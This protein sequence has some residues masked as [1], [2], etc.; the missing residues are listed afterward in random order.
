MSGIKDNSEHLEIDWYRVPIDKE[1]LKELNR[2]SDFKASLQ[3]LGHL[4]LLTL[5]GGT[6]IYGVGRWPWPL[7]VVLVFAHATFFHFLLNGFHELCHS[8]A[9]RTKWLGEAVLGLFSL[10][11]LNHHVAFRESHRRHHRYTLHAPYDSEVILPIRHALGP[12]LKSIFVNWRAYWIFRFNWR[13]AT[14]NIVHPWTRQLFP[15]S[16]PALRR[17]LFNWSRI[18]IAFHAAIIV[19]SMALA[20]GGHPR[21]LLLPLLTTF[22][23]FYGRWLNFLLND[24]QHVGLSDNVPDFRLCAR[25]IRVNPFLG[26]L[27]WQMQYHIEHHMYAGVPFYNLPKLN[28]LIRDQLPEPPN[29]LLATWRQIAAILKR[30]KEEPAYQY[31]PPLPLRWSEQLTP[32]PPAGA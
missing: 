16:K 30:Q 6:A 20:A 2:R 1:T 3:T 21:W 29:G 22:T 27:Y 24:T 11:S 18:C 31:R 14:G 12:V 10:L 26:F 32:A 28:R 4:G 23:H 8:T 7:I 17:K 13:L 15:E 9:F 19:L 25:S 5:T